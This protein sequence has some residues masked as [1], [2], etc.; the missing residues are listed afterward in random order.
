MKVLPGVVRVIPN[1]LLPL[2]FLAGPV[3]AQTVFVDDLENIGAN[4]TPITTRVIGGVT[5]TISTAAGTM[6]ARTYFD[7]TSYAFTG[8]AGND[9]AP[10]VPAN[11]SG[12][13][14]IS[15][16]GQNSH[17]MDHQPITFDF[18]T[19]VGAFGLTTIDLLES[20]SSSTPRYAP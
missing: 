1:F 9:N 6:T 4:W 11:V 18:S 7:S 10:L 15:T 12:S 16:S 20:G 2:L 8:A 13:R 19:P 17:F 3:S 5:V 14:F